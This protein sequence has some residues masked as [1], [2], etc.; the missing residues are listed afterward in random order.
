MYAMSVSDI[1][2]I[3]KNLFHILKEKYFQIDLQSK[4]HADG[5]I[6]LYRYSGKHS[7]SLF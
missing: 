7:E 2:M 1:A 6:K 4:I 5:N 3:L